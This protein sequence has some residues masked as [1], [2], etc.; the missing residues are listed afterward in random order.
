MET[1]A[2]KSIENSVVEAIMKAG[3]YDVGYTDLN[4]TPWGG[5]SVVKQFTDKLGLPTAMTHWNVPQPKSNR[6]YRPTQL[7]EQMMVAIWSGAGRYSQLDISRLDPALKNIFEWDQVAEH[8]AVTRFLSKFTANQSLELMRAVYCWAFNLMK[9][10]WVTLDVDSTALTR[11][12]NQDGAVPGYNPRNHGRN[13]HHPLLAM[14]GSIRMIANFWLRSGDAG[15]ANNLVRFLDQTMANLGNTSIGLLRADSGFYSYSTVEY[16]ESKCINYIISAKFTKAMQKA[17][18]DQCRNWKII[19]EGIE[20]S[21][22]HYWPTN[23]GH[24]IRIVVVRQN[25][26][27]RGKR[28]TPGKELSLFPDDAFEGQWR[29][30]AMAT[31]LLLEDTVVWDLYKQRADCENRIKELKEDFG[32]GS[33]VLKNFW[34]TEA[35]LTI[36][37]LAYNLMSMFRQYVLRKTV[38]P[39]LATLQRN[40]FAI[41]AV[42]KSTTDKRGRPILRLHIPLKRRKWFEGLWARASGYG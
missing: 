1:N 9:L 41:G 18:V 2:L 10:K 36:C 19:S 12:G 32:L 8:K 39:T 31:D 42:W 14:V 24:D 4:V 23:W 13:S 34:A 5:L 35:G 20:I 38:Q 25:I 11:Y 7:I 30:S 29:Y 17:M 28:N 21:D 33:F 22:F 6:G 15:T 26:S 16:L 27:R 40:V 37:M 3:H